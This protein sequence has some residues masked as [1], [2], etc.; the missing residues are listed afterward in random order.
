[1]VRASRV[2]GRGA[3][4]P[5]ALLD[6]VLGGQVLVLPVAAG[7][8]RLFMQVLGEGFRQAVGQG[9]DHDGVVVVQ[10]VL[11]LAG[12][13]FHADAR[14]DGEKAQVVG[15]AG[16]LGRD[17]VGQ[18]FVGVVPR[19][20]ALLAQRVDAGQDVRAAL[21]RIEF[22][23][24]AD[25]VSWE[26]AVDAVRPQ[27]LVGHKLCQKRLGLLKELAR[28]FAD[29]R[30]LQNVRV[31]AVQ[32]PGA[33]EGRPV[34]ERHEF[35]Q[36]QVGD[37]ADARERGPGDVCGLPNDGRSVG[38]RLGQR[39]GFL[40]GSFAGVL[41]AGLLLLTR[42]LGDVVRLLVIT[43]QGADHADG[44]GGVQDVD[45]R[46]PVVRGDLDGGVDSARGRAADQQRHLEILTLH[47]AGHMG[48]LVQ[49]GRNQAAQADD[50]HVL[51]A[52]FGKN[53]V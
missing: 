27:R 22:N 12:Q 32:L 41:V 29:G 53:L 42:D 26:K 31:A 52:R 9:A 2:A 34:N 21:I 36:R 45:D 28:A 33:E 3:D 8:A 19:L 40:V 15:Q 50:V 6:Q 35:R 20:L 5:V 11:E 44:A 38:A 14:R 30:V 51:L 39:Q 47:L 18:R 4:A 46:L 16:L 17:V 1:M 48:H 43:D 24:V 10:V 37:G 7:F 23:V 25:S 49:R 13:L